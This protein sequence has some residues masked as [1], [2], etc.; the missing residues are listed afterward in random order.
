MTKEFEIPTKIEVGDYITFYC[1]ANDCNVNKE[2]ENILKE[3]TARTI[4]AM[5][6]ANKNA[7]KDEK[8]GGSGAAQTTIVLD[9]AHKCMT[10]TG[11]AV[12]TA[13]CADDEKTCFIEAT[14]SKY[15]H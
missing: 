5:K 7:P 12:A 14:I 10:K 8:E 13:N 9:A 1:K 3:D 15:L 2:I 6:K 4:E 11:A